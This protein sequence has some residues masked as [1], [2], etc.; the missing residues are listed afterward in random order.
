MASGAFQ[1]IATSREPYSKDQ[2]KFINVKS[3]PKNKPSNIKLLTKLKAKISSNQRL[4]HKFTEEFAE[5]LL[6]HKKNRI[7]SSNTVKT[8]GKIQVHQYTILYSAI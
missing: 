5:H 7:I 6:L 2:F 4:K 1:I 8:T 3:K